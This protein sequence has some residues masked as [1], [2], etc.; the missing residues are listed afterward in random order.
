MQLTSF[1]HQLLYMYYTYTTYPPSLAVPSKGLTVG[2]KNMVVSEV[3]GTAEVC[4]DIK[5]NCS[6][7]FPF[8]VTASTHGHTAGNT[9]AEE[10]FRRHDR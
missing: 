4:I 3:A 1:V 9:C 2:S 7:S 10:L 6:A 8:N 5:W